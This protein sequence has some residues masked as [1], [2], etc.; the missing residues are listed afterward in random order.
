M[1]ADIVIGI[2]VG[3]PIV[4]REV[5]PHIREIVS[6]SSAITAHAYRMV[7]IQEADILIAPQV[8]SVDPYSNRQAEHAIKMGREATIAALPRIK[9]VMQ[10]RI[11]QQ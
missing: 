8:A 3:A 6:R 4:H 10:E 7:Q 5:K 1:G 9:A 11:I 2:D